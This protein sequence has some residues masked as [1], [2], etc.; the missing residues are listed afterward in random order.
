MASHQGIVFTALTWNLFHGRDF[1][2]DPGLLTLR[3]RLTRRT[4]LGATHAQVNRSLL[5]EFAAVLD[6]MRWEIALLQEVPPRWLRPLGLRCRASGALVLTS[7]NQLPALRTAA[8]RLNPDLVASNE[9]GSN[10][11]LVRAPGRIEPVERLTLSRRPERRTALLAKVHAPGAAALT[12]GCA[13]LSVPRTGQG[14][15]ELAE[16]AQ[17][18]LSVAAG[19]PLLLGGDLN[20]RPAHHGLAFKEAEE[21]FGLSGATPGKTIDHLLTRNLEIVSPAE[22]LPA[23]ARE[24]EGP[25]GLRIRLSDHAPVTADFGMR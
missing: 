16:L 24:V 17:R 3:S 8:A 7:R 19:G 15:R 12:V 9:G 14:A 2:P 13:H 1:P 25:A 22:P 11:V 18:A 21:R 23:E 6:G 10:V 5:A 4:E 20:L